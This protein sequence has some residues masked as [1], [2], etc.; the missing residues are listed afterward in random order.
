MCAGQTFYLQN[1][2]ALEGRNR[3][4]I[5]MGRTADKKMVLGC[6]KFSAPPREKVA[7]PTWVS[8]VILPHPM[9]SKSISRKQE[10]GQAGLAQWVGGDNFPASRKLCNVFDVYLRYYTTTLSRGQEGC[11]VPIF[12]RLPFAARATKPGRTE[13]RRLTSYLG[14]S[15]AYFIR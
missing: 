13:R 12:C 4:S 11:P 7:S 3:K 9:N 15:A 6:S 8:H 10:A 14:N 1:K 2:T 5:A